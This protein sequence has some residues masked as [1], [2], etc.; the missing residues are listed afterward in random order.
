[1]AKVANPRK[2]FNW[3]IEII[4]DPINPFL[5]QKVDLP[6]TEVEQVSHG[7]TNHDIKTAG[8]V[9]YS[10]IKAEKLMLSNQGDTYMW[11]WIDTCQ[12]SVLGGGAVPDIYKK[13]L[14]ITELAEDGTTPLNIWTAIGAWPCKVNGWSLDRLKS[15]NSLEN[16]E[17]SIDKLTK[18][19]LK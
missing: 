7:D 12:S 16:L 2:V 8:R 19:N 13:I 17:F 11:G 14:L 4:P 6:D 18:G 5:F 9:S 15:E 10:N 3:S 1:M